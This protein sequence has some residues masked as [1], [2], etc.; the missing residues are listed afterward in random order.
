[1]AYWKP[2]K[3][4]LDFPANY[5]FLL[6]YLPH[7][8][9]KNPNIQAFYKAV[10]LVFDKI[11]EYYN[12]IEKQ[13][14]VQYATGEFLDDLGALVEV[15]RNGQ[16]DERYRARIKLAFKQ[17]DFVP[18]LNNLLEL[19]KSYTGIYPDINVGWQNTLNFDPERYDINFYANPGYDFSI[20]YDL[21]IQRI[22][23]AGK[24]VNFKQC[25]I[26]Y[27]EYPYADDIYADDDKF[28]MNNKFNPNC[29]L[30]FDDLAFADSSYADDINYLDDDN[31][32]GV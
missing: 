32:K 29:Q 31:M 14:L 4:K 15:E 16:S 24:K 22:V 30:S 1:M 5:D 27:E 11:D 19:I 26:G 7:Y 10:S 3:V 12:V 13:W 2:K 25:F 9:S 6:Y 20:L 18:H 21:D 17:I 28:Y 23:G 8:M